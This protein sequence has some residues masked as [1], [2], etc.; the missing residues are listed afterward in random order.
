MNAFFTVVRTV[1]AL[2]ILGG[3]AAVAFIYSGL[4][5][6]SATTP[7]IPIVAWAVH[8][9]SEAS[10]AARLGANKVPSGLD[11]PETIKAGGRLFIENCAVCHGAP[12]V[13]PTPI[14]Q[15]LN[16]SPP[17]LF[18]ATRKPDEQEN[19]QFIKY[20][21]KMTAMP[22]FGK[23]LDDDHVWQTVAF[24]NKLPGMSKSDYAGLTAAPAPSAN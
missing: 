9:V 4:Y 8:A 7:D 12:E 11:K 23:S 3:A 20:G 14:A 2:A 1:V 24:L 5:D 18:A 22:G 17:N 13:A 19:F 16:P 10:V 6:V 21:V 15:G